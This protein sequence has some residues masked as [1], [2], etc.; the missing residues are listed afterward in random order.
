MPEWLSSHWPEGWTSWHVAALGIGLGVVLAVVSLFIVGYVLSRLPADYFV[1]PAAR[2]PIDR[3]PVLK[4]LVA[5]V[6]NGLGY[7]LIALGVVLSLPGVPGQGLLTIFMGVLL[8]DFPGKHG[9]ERWL[10]SQRV[11]LAGV[12]R[13]RAKAGQPPLEMK[14]RALLAERTEE[15]AI[16]QQLPHTP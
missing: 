7:A 10:V 2:R 1:N 14:E 11:I 8:I 6:R 3:H 12:N 5:I 9:F 15:C 16:S 4:V 13:L